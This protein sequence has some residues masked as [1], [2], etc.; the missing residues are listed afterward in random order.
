MNPTEEKRIVE[1]NLRLFM[2]QDA[3]VDN[4]ITEEK[5]RPSKKK[6]NLERRE[7]DLQKDDKAPLKPQLPRELKPLKPQLP[8]ELKPLKPKT[9]SLIEAIIKCRGLDLKPILD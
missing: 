3:L 7:S 9:Y 4:Y 1:L 6:T 5:N 2:M 8:R